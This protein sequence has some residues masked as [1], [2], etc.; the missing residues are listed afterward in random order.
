MLHFEIHGQKFKYPQN[1]R[2]QCNHF[3]LLTV[4]D[5]LVFAVAIFSYLDQ[6]RVV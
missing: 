5:L 1:Y 6:T 3:F 2:E 4:L